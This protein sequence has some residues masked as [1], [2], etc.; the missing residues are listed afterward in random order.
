MLK[1]ATIESPIGIWE[2]KELQK[3]MTPLIAMKMKGYEEGF[4]QK[5]LVA[6]LDTTDFIGNHV[7]VYMEQ[8]EKIIPLLA[9]KNCSL[10]RCEQFNIP[11]PIVS[12]ISLC[13][14]EEHSK[15]LNDFL[16]EKSKQ[17][18]NIAYDCSLTIN[19]I[20]KND[21]ELSYE[22]H[23]ILFA[24]GVLFKEENGIDISLM[25]ANLKFQ[26][27]KTFKKMG[28]KPMIIGDK[29]L[30]PVACPQHAYSELQIY[31]CDNSHSKK[32]IEMSKKYRSLWL[33][34]KHFSG[35]EQENEVEIPA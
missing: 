13:N 35:L 10:K 19:P 20:I 29:E 31:V 27:N 5:D 4:A 16:N 1:I 2:N 8:K 21:P 3:F 12:S 33:T 15:S 9:Y 14:S 24:L 11:F 34:R 6:P 7:M 17:G 23:S 30:A 28:A 32:A 26:T 25:L 22:V 18:Q